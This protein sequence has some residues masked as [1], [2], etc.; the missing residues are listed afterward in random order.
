ML[1]AQSGTLDKVEGITD[2][3]KHRLNHGELR[4]LTCVVPSEVEQSTPFTFLCTTLFYIVSF[5]DNDFAISFQKL[6]AI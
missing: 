5:F 6:L 3:T 1:V 4:A 2:G